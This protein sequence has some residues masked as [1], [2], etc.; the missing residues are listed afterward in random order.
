MSIS[1]I[2]TG[3]GEEYTM[4]H[5]FQLMVNHNASDLHM[6][7]DAPPSLRIMGDL[8]RTDLPVLDADKMIDM[9]Y[10]LLNKKQIG[11]LEDTGDLDFATEVPGLSRYRGNALFERNGLGAVF[12]LI[13]SKVPDIDTLGLPAS[14]KHICELR[15]GLVIVTGAT[16]NGKSTTLAA[17]IDYI[18]RRRS[19]H[20]ITVEDPVEFIH[21]NM[22]SL[23]IHRE[24]GLHS[25]T[26][27]SAINDAIKEDPDI[28][29]IGELRDFETITM[30]LKAADMGILVFGTLHTNSSS[31]TIDRIIDVFPPEQHSQVRSLLA[32]SL[33]A[34]VAQILVKTKDGRSR[35]PA[36]EVLIQTPG[37]CNMIR[38]GKTNM[39][40]TVIQSGR[41]V[42]M[43]S[44]DNALG[45]LVQ[46]G[47]IT[48]ETA[49]S[50]AIDITRLGVS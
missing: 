7:I 42:G 27:A 28:L 4:D 47:K 44:L 40:P 26:F 22:K 9:I 32:E 2:N 34:V 21:E 17:M 30:A 49:K 12:R 41:S 3:I 38:D 43:Q 36:V 5:L 14:L 33:Q 20:I 19:S 46:E 23:I 50:R 6:A 8:T 15:G 31:K 29:L 24:V 25:R 16:G 18:N 13:P 11:V 39:I 37:L 1:V 45:K 48:V 35:V 10:G